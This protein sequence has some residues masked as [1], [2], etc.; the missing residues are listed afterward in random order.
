MDRGS[1]QAT[2]H[3]VSK[4]QTGLSTHTEPLLAWCLGES[5]EQAPCRSALRQEQDQ[6]SNF[7]DFSGEEFIF[8]FTLH[9]TTWPHLPETYSL[10]SHTVL[11]SC[12]LI[13]C[14]RA[15]PFILDDFCWMLNS[16]KNKHFLAF[17][18]M[19]GN[20]ISYFYYSSSSP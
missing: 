8:A 19:H 18:H 3:G 7:I 4:S 10:G 16:C 11:P 17:C 9:H 6:K 5:K 20:C 12:V 13:G 14:Y 1:W 2:V 15:S